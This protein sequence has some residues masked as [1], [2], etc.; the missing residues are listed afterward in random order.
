[1]SLLSRSRRVAHLLTALAAASAAVGLTGPTPAARAQATTG[2]IRGR[3][4]SAADGTAMPGVTVTATSAERGDTTMEFT[5]ADGVYHL[6]GLLPGRYTLTFAFGEQ[7]HTVSGVRVSAGQITGLP[8]R[9]DPVG[10]VVEF[11]DSGAAINLLDPK[12]STVVDREILRDGVLVGRDFMAAASMAPGTAS[13]GVG[14]MIKG[15]SANESTVLIDGIPV[16]GLRLGTVGSSMRPEFLEEVE[17]ITGAYGAELGRSTGGVISAVTRSGTNELQGSLFGYLT[18][19]FL[20]GTRDRTPTQASAIDSQRDLAYQADVGFEVSGPIVRDK[21]WFFVGGGP[22]LARVDITRV[23]KRRTDCRR[24]EGGGLSSC[25]PD[26]AGYQDGMADIDPATGFYVTEDVDRAHLRATTAQYA[27]VAK[28]NVA[29]SEAHQGMVSASG[30][31]STG[32]DHRS[33]GRLDQ[34][35]VEQRGLVTDLG[36]KWTSSFADGKVVLDLVAGW[37]HSQLR[38]GTGDARRDDERLQALYFGDLGTWSQL[39]GESEATRAGCSDGGAADP[40]ALITNCPDEGVGY[41]TGGP[42]GLTRDREDRVSLA[43]SLTRRLSALGHHEFKLGGDVE[44]NRLSRARLFSGG[45][46]LQNYLG[47]IGRV[48]ATRWVQLAP[49]TGMAEADPRFDNRCVDDNRTDA[50]G[51]PVELACDFLAGDAGYPGTEV[52]GRTRNWSAYLRDAWSVRPNL[53]ISAGLRYEEQRLRYA[54]NLQ[55]T[56]DALTGRTLGT[57]ALVLRGMLAPRLG[58]IYDWTR[59]ARGKLFANWGRFYES[60]PLQINDRSFGGEVA[61]QQI[62]VGR[63]DGNQCGAAADGVGGVDGNRCLDDEATVAGAGNSLF[64]SSGVLVAPGL[65]AQYLDE[66]VLGAQYELADDTVV[67]LNLERRTMGRVIEDVSTDGAAT[68]V[69]ANPGEWSAEEE[70]CLA[71]RAAAEVDPAVRARLERELTMFRG[72]RAFDRPRRD[73]HA[74]ALTLSRRV[75]KGLYAQASYT[76]ARLRGNYPGLVSYDNGQIDPNISSQYDLIELLAN[77]TGPLPHDRPHYLKLDA[78]YRLDLGRAGTVT[79]AGRGR[80]LS[81]VPR[82][83]LGPHALYGADESFLLPRGSIGRTGL[84]HGLDLRVAYKRTLAR[85]AEAEI[86]ADVFNVYN[87]QGVAAVDETYALALPGNEVRPISGGS[88][89]DLVFAKAVVD[90]A[91]TAQTVVRNPNFG[92]VTGRYAPISARLGARVTF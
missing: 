47:A 8:A 78:I 59:V 79:L 50:A 32:R 17:V 74:L 52:V 12:T 10:E 20:V 1:M 65:R 2:G 82:D 75:S 70:A 22:A 80:V 19:G 15:G 77:R 60:I 88:Y 34:S 64:G 72:I 41:A 87:R 53:T 56:V 83:V 45:A 54:E 46:L 5:D 51:N 6:R 37:H 27:A 25:E 39:G 61:Y 84:E 92:A 66:A 63:G 71:A 36:S 73:Y 4:T 11:T 18:P 49:A 7:P 42:G 16:T 30:T 23:S 58:V 35:Q 55:G 21:A 76:Y 48:Y 26:Q 91:E 44:D 62:F 69:I 40:Y 13:D 38:D 81:G 85:G 33:Y 31:L 14:T 28:I 43:G 57:D 90:G 68:Y 89:Q 67:G 86:F 9:L 29:V 24:L 3:V